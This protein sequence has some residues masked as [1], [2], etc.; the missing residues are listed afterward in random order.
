MKRIALFGLLLLMAALTAACGLVGTGEEAA[1]KA[2]EIA[3]FTPPEGFNAEFSMDVGGMVMVGYN[4]ANSNSHIF[5]IQAPESSGV[6]REQLEQSL[7][8]AVA[9]GQSSSAVET[10]ST[11]EIPVTIRGEEVTATLGTGTSGANNERNVRMLTVPFDGN[12]GPALLLYQTDEAEWDQ[13]EVD[14]L[15]ASFR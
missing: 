11:E 9:S 13:A 6:T 12:G 4:R 2:T 5:L 15:L 1:Q 8:D 10:I 3:E 14:A 7:H